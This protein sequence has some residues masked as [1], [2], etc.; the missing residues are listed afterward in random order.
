MP[1]MTVRALSLAVL[2]AVAVALHGCARADEPAAP[3]ASI[4]VTPSSA[5][6]GV[7]APIDLAYQ[8]TRVTGGP[9]LTDDLYAFVHF[10]DDSGMLLWT[11]DHRP[12]VAPSR[13]SGDAASYRRTVFVPRMAYSGRVHVQ[14]GLYV[15]PNGPRLALTGT[16]TGDKS[17]AVASFDVGPDRDG[18][19][20]TFG[21]G[22]H[23][24]ERAA[25]EPLR[26]W[27]WSSGE[28]H[29]S[30]RAPGRDAVLWLELDQPV[31][32]VGAQRLEVRIGSDLLA[33]VPIAPGTR[34]VQQV[35]LPADRIAGP[36]VDL[37][38]TVT[39]TFVPS[40]VAALGSQ[41]SRQLGI[42]VFNVY[43]AVR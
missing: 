2:T 33:T 36:M 17:Y 11:D 32:Q 31:T 13:W 4:A 22:W 40:T 34:V 26:E 10:V 16:A 3:V 18:V 28:A 37:A 14:A 8:W 24:A 39:P 12:P 38:L 19:F 20:V 23:G 42:R 7:G 9:A 21:D 15:P 41:D 29:V 5:S 25:Q 1:W 35:P 27:R 43:V 30:F 6:V